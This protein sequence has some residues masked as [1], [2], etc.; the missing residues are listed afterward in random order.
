MGKN[1]KIAIMD[2]DLKRYSG[3]DRDKVKIKG[4]RSG[5]SYDRSDTLKD[6]MCGE[7]YPFYFT[8]SD[9]RIWIRFKSN[10]KN[11]DRGFVAGYVMYDSTETRSGGS[12]TTAGI[13]VGIIIPL[14]IVACVCYACVYRRRQARRAQQQGTVAHVTVPP[15]EMTVQHPPPPPQPGYVPLPQQGYA[16]PPQPGYVPPPQQ[17][18]GPQ[19]PGY[20]P[21]P[22][23]PPPYSQV[24]GTPYPQQGE[25][26]KSMFCVILCT[27]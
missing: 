8:S 26:I 4:G 18:Y 24:A 14:V 7:K 11:T 12:V 23:P 3:C 6:S 9:R 22:Q 16:P 1:V 2:F 25:L 10:S 13:V 17:G 15:Q 20:A 5:D 21:P 27:R 19:Q